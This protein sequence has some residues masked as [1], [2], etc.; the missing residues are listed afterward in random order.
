MRILLLAKKNP[1]P[2]KDG[3]AIAIMH[4]AEGLHTCGAEVH[5]LY[6]NT[7]KHHCA[8]EDIPAEYTDRIHFHSVWV[9]A[10]LHAGGALKN[11]FSKKPWHI[12]RFQSKTFAMRLEKLLHTHAFDIVQSEGLMCTQYFPISREHSDAI[13]VYRSHNIEGAIW[14]HVAAHTKNILRKWYIGIQS[15][16]LFSYES[17][18]LSAVDAIVPISRTDAAYYANTFPREKICYIP[19]GLDT[20]QNFPEPVAQTSDLYFIGGLDWIPNREGLHWFLEKVFPK[21]R[22]AFP[23]IQF[24]IAG[25]NAPAYM[26]TLRDPGVIFH[27]EVS[28]A[29]TYASNKAIC[30][31]PLLSGSGMKIKIMEAM[32]AGKFVITTAV[33]AEGLPE[34]MSA[35]MDVQTDPDSFAQ[36]LMA[37]LSDMTQTLQKAQAGKEFVRTH[38]DNTALAQKLIQFYQ[39]L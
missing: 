24:H 19:T 20:K 13:C 36:A 12:T 8:V 33:G 29:Q 38:L 26:E 18:I 14:H 9:D 27:G 11:L 3:E 35:C 39:T 23:E 17:D 28:D 15:A 4:M 22:I 7:P 2:V 5:I 25:R 16:K 34:G 21:V 30:V 32:A 6:M 10:A 1:Y 37:R 31:V